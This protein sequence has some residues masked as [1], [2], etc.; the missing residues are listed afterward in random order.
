MIKTVSAGIVTYNPDINILHSN[1]NA[2]IDQVEKIYIYDNGSGNI[3][4]ISLLINTIQNSRIILISN[5]QNKGIAFALNRI[6]EISAENGFSWVI[7]LDQDSVV[8]P[9]IISDN[10][11]IIN[12]ESDSDLAIIGCIVN[13]RNVHKIADKKKEKYN[14][15]PFWITS[16][17]ITNV[18]IWEKIGGF[19]EEM[20]IDFVDIEYCLRAGMNGYKILVNDDVILSHTIGNTEE[21]FGGLLVIRNHSSIRKYYQVRNLLYMNFKLYKKISAEV[22]LKIIAAY[23]KVIFFEDKKIEKIKKLSNGLCDGMKYRKKF[24]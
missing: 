18:R 3:D 14:L 16:G 9:N 23:L 2:I 13:D 7:T 21:K 20:F 4:E 24:N 12:S 1:I 10:F 22:L 6:M 15:E 5:E 8:P 19:D 17:S 11:D